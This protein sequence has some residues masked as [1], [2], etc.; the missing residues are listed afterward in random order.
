MSHAFIRESEGQ[1]LNEI[2]PGMNSLISYLTRDNN[3]VR[4]YEKKCSYDE[5]EGREVHL[6]SNGLSYALDDQSKWYI[7]A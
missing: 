1:W 7:V 6:M 2:G 5:K 4:I 3:G